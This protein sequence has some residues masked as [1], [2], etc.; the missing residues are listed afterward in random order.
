M[1]WV[2][3]LWRW[4]DTP[5]G[6]I[7]IL[8]W[9]R[10]ANQKQERHFQR[11]LVLPF[12]PRL[13]ANAFFSKLLQCAM[14]LA[15]GQVFFLPSSQSLLVHFPNLHNFTVTMRAWSEEKSTVRLLSVYFES[16]YS[17]PHNTVILWFSTSFQ[18]KSVQGINK[19]I[20]TDKEIVSKKTP[21]RVWVSKV[22]EIEPS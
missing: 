9:Q 3:W 2:W 19:Q 11:T 22:N 20:K 12:D 5:G 1:L 10:E 16:V 4:Q 15:S 13:R 8:P 21:S 7:H 17:Q 14:N 18:V 6:A